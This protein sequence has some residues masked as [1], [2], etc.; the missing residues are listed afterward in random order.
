MK[1]S[2]NYEILNSQINSEKSL[3]IYSELIQKIKKNIVD[4][5]PENIDEITQAMINNILDIRS[6]E[7]S[8]LEIK[9]EKILLN[10]FLN[11]TLL[12]HKIQAERKKITVSYENNFPAKTVFLDKQSLSRILDN[13]LS[14]LLIL[15]LAKLRFLEIFD[16]IFLLL[17]LFLMFKCILSFSF[18]QADTASTEA[19]LG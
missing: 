2:S 13:L 6:I 3:E 7:E 5:I 9:C 1:N 12:G 18:S 17:S 15:V 10:E 16:L 19:I 8:G 11:T 4:L 14:K